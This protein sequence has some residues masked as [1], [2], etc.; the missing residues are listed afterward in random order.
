[1][2]IPNAFVL[3]VLIVVRN[4]LSKY[5]LFEKSNLVF[6][7]TRVVVD[8]QGK[9]RKVAHHNFF[10]IGHGAR[11]YQWRLQPLLRLDP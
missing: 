11:Q 2:V 7:Y 6:P 10:T 5:N 4:G 3:M 9:T 8:L 1:M